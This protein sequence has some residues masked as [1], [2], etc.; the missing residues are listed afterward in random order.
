[1]YHVS[2]VYLGAVITTIDYKLILKCLIFVLF[3]F[4]STACFGLS[5]SAVVVLTAAKYTFKPQRC[6][7]YK[8]LSGF[9]KIDTIFVVII[10][11]VTVIVMMEVVNCAFLY[12]DTL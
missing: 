7:R 2:N 11:V 6:F 4:Y 1:V 8:L 3:Y 5:R 9:V 12:S 10:F